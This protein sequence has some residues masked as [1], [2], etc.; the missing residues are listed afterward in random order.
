MAC[1]TV[2]FRGSLHE[3]EAGAVPFGLGITARTQTEDMFPLPALNF[4]FLCGRFS[5]NFDLKWADGSLKTRLHVMVEGMEQA[6]AGWSSASRRAA[7]RCDA[8]L[9]MTDAL[10]VSASVGGPAEQY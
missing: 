1:W 6:R 2:A 5:G 8:W 4:V 9:E 10:L 7:M 3:H